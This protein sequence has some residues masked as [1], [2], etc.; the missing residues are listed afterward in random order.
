[1]ICLISFSKLPDVFPDFACTG[2]IDNLWSLCLGV[3]I[4]RLKWS[5]NTVFFNFLFLLS[6]FLASSVNVFSGITS[7]IV[8]FKLLK[9]Q[10]AFPCSSIVFICFPNALPNEQYVILACSII[11]LWS[12]G[13]I[14]SPVRNSYYKFY[15]MRML[16]F[17]LILC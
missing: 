13:I 3:Y 10:L 11:L 4:L 8:N 15:L 12:D 14:S 16:I 2:A 6:S 9:L 5:E 17:L 1:M 7:F